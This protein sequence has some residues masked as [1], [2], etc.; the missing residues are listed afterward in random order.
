MILLTRLL[1]NM[2]LWRRDAFLKSAADIDPAIKRQL[3]A[4]PIHEA[5]TLFNGKLNDLCPAYSVKSLPSLSL[6][7]PHFTAAAQKFPQ[8]KRG[9]A[10]A[11]GKGKK[12][13]NKPTTQQQQMKQDFTVLLPS[14][15]DDSSIA[16]KRKGSFRGGR[17]GK[18]RF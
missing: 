2:V 14:G 5:T 11:K 7:P 8:A 9:F 4:Q 1:T 3:R 15:T 10:A 16:V 13:A 17:Q 6:Q 12:S 18:Q